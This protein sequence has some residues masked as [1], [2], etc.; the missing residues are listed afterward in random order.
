MK[1]RMQ[2]RY[3]LYSP[4]YYRERSANYYEIPQNP[5]WNREKGDNNN[6]SGS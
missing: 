3:G 1:S 2:N 5:V 4:I 6:K